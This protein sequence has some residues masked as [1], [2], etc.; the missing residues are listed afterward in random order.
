MRAG[1]AIL[2]LLVAIPAFA[3]DQGQWDHSDPETSKWFQSLKQPDNKLMSCCGEG[4]GYW[5]DK[6]NVTEFGEMVATIT[7]ERDDEILKR[8]HVPPGTQYIVPPNKVIDARVQG[9]NPTGHTIV[10]L[11]AISWENN[12]Q[13]PEKRQVICYVMGWGT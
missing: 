6:V 1:I 2:I 8:G 11:N 3:R 9:G 13:H 5:A 10:F 4:D 7:D 12:V